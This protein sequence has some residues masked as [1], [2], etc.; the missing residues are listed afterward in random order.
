MDPYDEHF[1][2][3]G[4]IEDAD[5]SAFRQT[6]RRTPEKIMVQFLRTGMLE[7]EHLA[8]L[9]IDPRHHVPDN[10]VLSGGVH[11][12]KISSRA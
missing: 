3:V 10:A 1:L 7:A 6:A 9:G 2:I 4:A 11:T 8:A 12:V 5:P